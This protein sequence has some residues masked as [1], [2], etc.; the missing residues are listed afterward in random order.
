M[1]RVLVVALLAVLVATPAGAQQHASVTILQFSDVPDLEPRAPTG[2]LPRIATVI[3]WEKVRHP[4]L[5]VVHGGNAFSP[6]PVASLDRGEHMSRLLGQMLV[7]VMVAN[8][9]E[10]DFGPDVASRRFAEL[11]FPV[12]GANVMDGTRRA[13]GLAD[14]TVVAAGGFRIGFVGGVNGDTRDLPIP[15]VGRLT[16]AP[17]VPALR[18]AAA[19]MRAQG[20]D[21]VIALCAGSAAECAAVLAEPGI[22]LVL[23][24]AGSDPGDARSDGRRVLLRS[25]AQGNVMAALD[26]E[27]VSTPRDVGVDL[28]NSFDPLRGAPNAAAPVRPDQAVSWSATTRLIDTRVVEPDQMIEAITQIELD[29]S[30][31][32]L[33]ERIGTFS[34]PFSAR[35]DL[36]WRQESSIADLVTDA[37]RQQA[38]ADVALL[39]AGQIRGD[40]DYDEGSSVTVRTV[41]EALPFGNEAERRKGRHAVGA[42]RGHPA[43]GL[44]WHG[45]PRLVRRLSAGAAAL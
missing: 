40:H 4:N 24:S 37:V 3:A 29:T 45:H 34:A 30:S 44:D 31:M 41:V 33:G 1:P 43:H 9:H 13:A 42:Q 18:A 14:G 21:V 36:M 2:D 35:S 19:A 16:F 17:L 10:F 15:G 39:E 27:L 38:A 25:G 22:D 28:G 26:L 20:A 6:S 5:I 11:S 32:A 23:G 7:D 8:I 12:L